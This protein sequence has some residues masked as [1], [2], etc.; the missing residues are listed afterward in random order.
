MIAPDAT[1][2]LGFMLQ[3]ARSLVDGL[4]VYPERLQENLERTGELFYSEAVMIALVQKGLPRQKAY[5]M[6]Q[7]NAMRAFE[8]AGKFRALLAAD[9]DLGQKL[10]PAELDEC[11][12]LEHALR[13]AESL[14]ERAIA[15]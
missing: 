7:R 15:S 2:T 5:E 3:R 10:T 4:V 6:V 12:D 14:V 11:F 1:A 13:Y 8:G 9:T